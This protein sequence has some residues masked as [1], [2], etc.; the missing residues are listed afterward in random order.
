MQDVNYKVFPNRRALRWIAPLGAFV[1]VAA[2][3]AF[4][5][6]PGSPMQ[7]AVLVITFLF[8][9]GFVRDCL[10][11]VSERPLLWVGTD[12]F[13]LYSP[14]GFVSIPYDEIDKVRVIN[15]FF[16][17]VLVVRLRNKDSATF[18]SAWGKAF[19]TLLRVG[20]TNTHRI[21]SY[22]LTGDVG[23]V[24]NLIRKRKEG[25]EAERKNRFE[26]TRDGKKMELREELEPES[27]DGAERQ[28]TLF[29]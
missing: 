10:A 19:Y 17:R 26:V 2:P 12:H 18:E 27:A 3:A 4:R 23:A 28:A 9:M 29:Q 15:Y 11:L 20:S 22:M 21:Q 25:V 1:V 13:K 14:F 7:M 8:F 5:M 16:V 24:A 6:S